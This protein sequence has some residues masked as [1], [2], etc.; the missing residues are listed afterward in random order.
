MELMVVQLLL[1]RLGCARLICGEDTFHILVSI[2]SDSYTSESQPTGL[3]LHMP[4]GTV[5]K[6]EG[7]VSAMEKLC[8][9]KIVYTRVLE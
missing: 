4:A 3:D 2:P 5:H 8:K 1:F 9:I 7:P 6:L